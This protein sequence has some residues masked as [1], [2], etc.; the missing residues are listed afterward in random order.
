M[1][2]RKEL[3]TAYE[4]KHRE[5]TATLKQSLRALEDMPHR[6]DPSIDWGNVGDLNRAQELAKH[7]LDVVTPKVAQ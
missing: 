7:V 1:S 4:A 2:D 6:S 3:E 5:L